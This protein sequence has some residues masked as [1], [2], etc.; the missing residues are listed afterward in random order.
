MSSPGV[1]AM[2]PGTG[3]HGT[4]EVAGPADV[5]VLSGVIA[6]AFADLAP[7]RWL[8]SDPAARRQIF[9]S[10]FR[11]PVEHALAAG[12]ACT[13]TDR[14]A[15]A[16]W[17]PAGPGPAG[18]PGGYAARLAAVTGP[19]ISRFLAFDAALGSSHPAGIPHQHLAVLAVRPDRQG[20]G[21][22]TA[23]LRDRHAALDRGEGLPASRKPPAPRTRRLYLAHG[24][25]DH[26]SPICLPGGP[27][28]YPMWRPPRT[29]LD[30]RSPATGTLTGRKTQ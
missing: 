26:G 5:E 13:T 30:T 25:T 8:I 18:P 27:L 2:P 11:L 6:A 16:L 19:W 22:G 20:H 23:L 24:Y 4:V 29:G 3:G 10:Y 15:V 17:L 12:L 1:P 7:S 9:P 28:M 21:A 14:S